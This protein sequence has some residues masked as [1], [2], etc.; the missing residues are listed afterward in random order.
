MHPGI[1]D[2]AIWQVA[3]YE[4]KRHGDD[5][6]GYAAGR[7]ERLSGLGDSEGSLAW[8]RILRAIET[9]RREAPA[10]DETID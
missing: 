1:D 7:A 9:L 2:T 10:A 5:A 3:A 6:I 4:L 8:A